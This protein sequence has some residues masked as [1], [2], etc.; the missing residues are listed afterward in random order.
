MTSESMPS[1]E[2][3]GD[4]KKEPTLEEKIRHLLDLMKRALSQN[5][6][7][8]FKEFWE[9][10]KELIP[11]FKERG[12]SF[13][14]NQ[15]WK[16]FID[17]SS[18]ARKLK[19]VL[20]EH[21]LFAVEQLELALKALRKDLEAVKDL[22]CPVER[23]FLSEKSKVLSPEKEKISSLQREIYLLSVL[24]Q[25]LHSL[26]KEVIQTPMRMRKKNEFFKEMGELGDAL[27]PRR[28]AKIEELSSLFK[29]A[30]SSFV[31]ENKK[32]EELHSKFPC[33]VLLQEIKA[34]Q[35]CAKELSLTPG[36][37]LQ[38]RELLSLFWDVVKR[39]ER[40]RKKDLL[41]KKQGKVK[42][43]TIFQEKM[44]LFIQKCGEEKGSLK[45][46]EKERDLLEKDLN[47]LFLSPKEIKICKDQLKRCLDPFYEKLKRQVQEKE[48]KKHQKVEEIKQELLA[49]LQDSTEGFSKKYQDLVSSLDFSSMEGF[50]A[51]YV[52]HLF[53]RLEEKFLQKGESSIEE[54]EQRIV[55][56]K[57]RCD[58]YRKILASS[59]LDFSKAF[60]LQEMVEAEK[61]LIKTLSSFFE[62]ED[63]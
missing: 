44:D 11:L 51:L 63:F 37:F 14:K 58:S 39:E 32:G 23:V 35:T 57:Q 28:K 20:E 55:A 3:Q 45:E 8:Q 62:E 13:I 5:D 59:N 40:L 46:L 15:M 26:R 17:L 9:V 31:L 60:L 52:R 36:V 43:H 56:S 25:K 22:S 24:G 38:V 54:I 19:G 61:D 42:E 29:T 33:Y 30:C 48:E 6:S 21:S 49:L 47:G 7:P 41:E 12:V 53:S 27:F 16:E 1:R 2:K 10:R 18:E 50:D 34:L 4:C